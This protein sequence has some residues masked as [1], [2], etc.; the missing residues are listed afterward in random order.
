MIP[1]AD[2]YKP[3]TEYA[4][5]LIERIGKTQEW[6]ARRLGVTSRRVRY[7]AHGVRITNGVPGPIYMSYTEQFTLEC[8]AAAIESAADLA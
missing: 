7:I 8:L 4:R 2:N 1:N 6:I 3:S 5:E